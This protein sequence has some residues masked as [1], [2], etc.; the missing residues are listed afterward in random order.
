[1]RTGRR[2]RVMNVYA[3]RCLRHTLHFRRRRPIFLRCSIRHAMLRAAAAADTRRLRTETAY[4]FADAC[5]FDAMLSI[6]C[7]QL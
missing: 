3:S 1:M 4:N 6:D 5:R 2:L 7:C